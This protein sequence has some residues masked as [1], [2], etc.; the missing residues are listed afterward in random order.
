MP[1]FTSVT[2]YTVKSNLV[3]IPVLKDRYEVVIWSDL[4]ILLFNF[5]EKHMGKWSLKE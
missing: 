1:P 2:F 5:L 4:L 3:I